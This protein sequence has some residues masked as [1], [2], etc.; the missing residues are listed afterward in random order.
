MGPPWGGVGQFF[1]LA[2]NMSP[3]STR[4]GP[5]CAKFVAVR[6]SCRKGRV[7]RITQC[8][9]YVSAVKTSM[10]ARSACIQLHVPVRV[11]VSVCLCALNKYMITTVYLNFRNVLCWIRTCGM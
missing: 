10:R 1:L 6:R 11:H 3:I 4:I 5:M 7:V 2:E 9:F 8:G